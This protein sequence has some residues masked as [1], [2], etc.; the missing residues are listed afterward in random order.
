MEVNALTSR[1][2][3]TMK[4]QARCTITSHLR[5]LPAFSSRPFSQFPTRRKRCTTKSTSSTRPFSTSIRSLQGPLSQT[6]Q[7][8]T[9]LNSQPPSNPSTAPKP[10]I[11]GEMTKKLRTQSSDYVPDKRPLAEQL[12]IFD[13]IMDVMSSDLK[14]RPTPSALSG[15]DEGVDQEALYNNLAGAAYRQSD[16]PK[17]SLRLKPSLGRTLPLDLTRNID[18]TAAFRRLERKC[19]DNSVK[20]D[21]RNQRFYVRRGQRRKDDR[22]RRWRALFKEGVLHEG[23][24]I[25]RMKAQGG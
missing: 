6:R 23:A 13:D 20:T 18:L 4:Q 1:C 3:C 9:P 19:A 14:R 12:N 25:R 5:S 16:K 10:S 17:V 22:R 15:E 7:Q 11:M 21:A 24:R 8:T 2:L